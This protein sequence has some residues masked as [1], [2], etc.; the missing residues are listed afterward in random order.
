MW[1]WLDC[2]AWRL[3]PPTISWPVSSYC[4]YRTRHGG[5]QQTVSSGEIGWPVDWWIDQEFQ[6][7]H[8]LQWNR[9]EETGSVSPIVFENMITFKAKKDLIK[10]LFSY[11]IFDFFWLILNFVSNKNLRLNYTWKLIRYE[12]GRLTKYWMFKQ[13]KS[14]LSSHSKDSFERLEMWHF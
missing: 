10:G 12:S 14:S 1:W 4:L 5:C 3:L 2:W 9:S 13:G 8:H 6:A 11:I 7:N